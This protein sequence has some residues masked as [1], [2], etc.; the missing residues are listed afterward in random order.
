MISSQ[1]TALAEKTL[2]F[3]LESGASQARVTLTRSVMN[4][5]ST[6]NNETDKVS[7]CLDRAIMLALFVDGRYGSYSTN[8]LQEQDLRTFVQQAVEMT[9]LLAPDPCRSLP[10]PG[11]CCTDAVTGDELRIYDHSISEASEAVGAERSEDGFGPKQAAGANDYSIISTESEYSENEID[12]LLLDSNGVRCRQMETSFE[13]VMEYTLED[14]QG[15]KY[16][17]YWWDGNP[18]KDHLDTEAIDREALRRTVAQMHPKEIDGGKYKI[19]VES[20]AASKLV[21][22]LLNALGGFALQ[23]KNSFLDGSLGKKVFSKG[24]TIVDEPHRKGETGSHLFD[25]EGVATIEAPIIEEGVVKRYF[26]S[27]Y[28][29]RKMQMEPTGED[30]AR[31]VVKPWVDSSLRGTWGHEDKLDCAHLMKLCAEGILVTGFNGGNSNS[32]TGDFSYGIEGFYFKDGRIVHP[33]HEML[34]TGNFIEL[35][36]NLL[37]CAED[38]RICMSKLIPSLAFKDVDIT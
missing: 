19:I 29:A 2:Q 10:D 33:V 14:R 32:A 18:R 11:R 1:E 22:P 31:P 30:P 15:N 20:N 9:R 8:K 5:V 17:G 16:N 28:M 23:Q 4:S 38:Y 26:L 24:L 27:D 35:W 34:M 36:N 13:Y 7:R 25:S 3:A 6:L 21:T 12:T 37:A